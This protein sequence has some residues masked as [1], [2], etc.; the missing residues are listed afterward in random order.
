MVNTTRARL[1]TQL[2]KSLSKSLFVEVQT[3]DEPIPLTISPLMAEKFIVMRAKFSPDWL[4]PFSTFGFYPRS[5]AKICG[6]WSL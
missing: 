6:Q 2:P 5:S 3:N 1:F 4:Q